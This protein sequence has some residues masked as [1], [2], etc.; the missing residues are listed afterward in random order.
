MADLDRQASETG[1]LKLMLYF[2]PVFGIIPALWSL[3]SETS[4][5]T[6]RNASRVAVKLA[7]TWFASYMLFDIGAQNI[8]ALHLPLLLTSSLITSGY[9]V[10]NLWLVIL[11]WQRKSI[12]VP[13]LGKVD[14]LD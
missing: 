4:T 3:N 9:F 10:M 12:D 6:E 8:D 1:S 14:R 2:M 7:L 11:L 5:R 13:L